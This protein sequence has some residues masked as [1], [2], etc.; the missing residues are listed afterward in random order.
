M[1]IDK[2]Y[3]YRYWDFIL[4][5]LIIALAALLRSG[6]LSVPLQR[7]EGEYAYTA[8]LILQGI[9]PY[10]EAYS[11]K[12]PGIYGIYAILLTLLDKT[13]TGIHLGLLVVNGATIV[14]LFYWQEMHSTLLPQLL[15]L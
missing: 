7:D 15:L 5:V 6:L 1:T 2:T 4:L 11:M 12:M 9:P 10:A 8:Q 14:L 3:L 13:H